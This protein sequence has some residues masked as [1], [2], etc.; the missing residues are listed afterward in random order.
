MLRMSKL[1][2]YGTMVLAQLAVRDGTLSTTAQVALVLES[3][4]RRTGGDG[5]RAHIADAV[6]GGLGATTAHHQQHGTV[7]RMDDKIAHWERLTANEILDLA[8]V[9]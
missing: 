2:D 9:A 1:T 6:Q 5:F 3:G 8:G 4:V 7:A